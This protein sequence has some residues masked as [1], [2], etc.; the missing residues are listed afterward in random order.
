MFGIRSMW[1]T[2]LLAAAGLMLAN[3]V[4]LGGPLGLRLG[5][6]G[7]LPYGGF[8]FYYP[9]YYAAPFAYG[10]YGP[11]YGFTI[12]YGYGVYGMRLGYGLGYGGFGYGVPGA[13]ALGAGFGSPRA[14]PGNPLVQQPGQPGPMP[15]APPQRLRPSQIPQPTPV[16]PD[17]QEE[18]APAQ[19]NTARVT[20]V[21]P[22]RAELWFNDAKTNQTGKRRE[23]ATA[24]LTPGKDFRY[25]IKARWIEDGK[26]VERTQTIKVRANSSQTVDFTK[27]RKAPLPE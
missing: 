23:F 17:E 9:G 4:A 8:G 10:V 13:G 7:V 3:G 1:K 25:R 6:V 18:K 26:L 12:R 5:N 11:G 19:D 16:P 24:P 20:V 22:E 15:Q 2:G 14:L 27:I 21:V